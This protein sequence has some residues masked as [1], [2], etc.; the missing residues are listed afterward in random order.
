MTEIADAQNPLAGVLSADQVDALVNAAE[1]LGEGRHGVE[2]LLSRMTQA[3]LE[4]ALETEMSDHLG[5]ES[6][7][8]AGAGTGNSRNGKT[9]KSI[10]TRLFPVRGDG[11]RRVV[12]VERLVVLL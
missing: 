5:Y 4:R 10:H 1:D 8:P 6:G 12:D 7:D 11:E 3:V 2:E 9:T